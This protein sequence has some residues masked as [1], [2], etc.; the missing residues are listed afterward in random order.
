MTNNCD[1]F[2]SYKW[3][4][5]S[6]ANCRSCSDVV[7]ASLTFLTLNNIQTSLC[8]ARLIGK[9]FDKRSGRA[10]CIRSPL[11]CL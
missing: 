9:F 8:C 7:F 11:A 3:K 5:L 6:T 1:I 4:S 10:E 2:I